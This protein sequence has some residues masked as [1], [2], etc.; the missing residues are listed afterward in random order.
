MNGVIK[1]FEKLSAAELEEMSQ[2]DLETLTAR[3]AVAHIHANCT[4][5][6]VALAN[7]KLDRDDIRKLILVREVF[8]EVLQKAFPNREW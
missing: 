5:I 8:R 3:F 6:D 7:N 4:A 2:E 1:D